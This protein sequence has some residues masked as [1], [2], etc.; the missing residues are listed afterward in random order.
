MEGGG[1][2]IMCGVRMIT[3]G[4]V[5]ESTSQSLFGSWHIRIVALLAGVLTLEL[6]NPFW[7]GVRV[8][9]DVVEVASPCWEE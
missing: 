1:S 6:A 8:V 3:V 5:T 7:R 2:E 9:E 4:P